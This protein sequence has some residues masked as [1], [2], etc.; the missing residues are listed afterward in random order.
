[1]TRKA[2]LIGINY[3]GTNAELN[4]CINDVINIKNYLIS[5]CGYKIGEIAMLTEA[6]KK[7]KPTRQN[8]INYINW[9]VK[10]NKA[11]SRLFF[12]YSGHG[13]YIKD[14]SKDEKDGRDETIC[15][16]DY[17][18]G[19]MLVDDQL[20]KLMVDPLCRG[21]KLTAVFDCCHSGTILDLRCNYSVNSN[22]RNTRYSVSIDKHYKSSLGDI[23]LLSGCMDSQVSAD[24]YEERQSQGAMTYALLKTLKK[25]NNKKKTGTYKGIIKNMTVFIKQKGYKQLPQLST[26]H[27]KDLNSQFY[28]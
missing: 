25:Y 28:I 24:T 18:S 1:M 16:L 14:R 3:I 11:D 20:K 26:G 9:L 15:P 27:L 10:D 12:H 6:S 23:T 22:P 4:G 7:K 8:I 19:G 2:L 21:A 13:S 17:S 5:N